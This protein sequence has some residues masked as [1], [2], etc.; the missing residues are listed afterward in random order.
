MQLLNIAQVCKL[1]SLSKSSVYRLEEKG[2]F[3]QRV[4]LSV[5]RVAWRNEDIQQWITQSRTVGDK[6]ADRLS[7]YLK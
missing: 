1:T 7:S 6:P 3:P 5:G 2:M 4:R